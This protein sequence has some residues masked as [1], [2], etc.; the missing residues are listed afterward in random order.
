[1]IGAETHVRTCP[2]K[3]ERGDDYSLLLAITKEMAKGGVALPAN[4]GAA[5]GDSKEEL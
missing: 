2:P 3:E 1:M 5:E 4:V